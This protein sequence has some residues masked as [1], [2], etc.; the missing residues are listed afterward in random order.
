MMDLFAA[1]LAA[2]SLLVALAGLRA[3]RR[4]KEDR[5]LLNR[6]EVQVAAGPRRAPGGPL[7]EGLANRVTGRRW[8][9]RLKRRAGAHHPG[10]P[11]S[12]YLAIAA[13]SF[14]AG[15]MVGMFLFGGVLV[16]LAAAAAAPFVV[17][18][19]FV[20][21]HGSRAARIE[22][23]LPEA[24]A[25]QANLLRA[26]QSLSKS[27]RIMSGEVKAPL[28][29]ELERMLAE[30][31]FGRPMDEALERLG[32]RI[33]SKDLDMWVTAML[34]HRQTGGNLAAVMDS[35]SQRVTQ[36]LQLRSEIRAMTA[37]GRLS[38]IVVSVAPLVFFSFMSLGSRDQMEFLFTT[39][40]GLLVLT[41]GLT[42]NLAGMFW[43]RRTLRIRA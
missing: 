5:A 16:P 17:D 41:C 29:E 6:L 32:A 35:S 20:R 18:R 9:A 3:K 15:G 43:I 40:L 37:Q 1:I 4:S 39:G 2:F 31:D 27:L 21:L 8:G 24:L 34:V 36:R 11:F 19:F 12:D 14:L 7:L 23:Q 33:P 13:A 25:L 22:K 10:V 30:V 38:G 26:G 42:M 28:G